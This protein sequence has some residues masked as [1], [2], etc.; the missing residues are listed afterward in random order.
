MIYA[1]VYTALATLHLPLAAT[2][3]IP[4]TGSTYP[5]SYLVYSVPSA[6][7]EQAADDGETLR[8]VRVQVN[9]WS[10]AGL[11]TP[12]AI[13]AAMLAAGFTSGPWRELPYSQDTGHYGLSWD[14][15]KLEE[16]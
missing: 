10:R 14:F 3:Y 15:F 12:P 6:A 13:E 8:S 2:V 7:P 11:A 5:D 1:D 16:T 9:W 4:A